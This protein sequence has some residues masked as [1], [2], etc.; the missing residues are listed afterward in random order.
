M[1]KPRPR[2]KAGGRGSS[3]KAATRQ[4][5]TRTHAALVRV[6]ADPE[7]VARAVAGEFVRLAHKRHAKGH[8]FRVALSGGATPRRSYEI[9]AEAPF[10]DMVDWKGV[11]FFWGDERCVPPEHPDSNYRMAL[12]A[13]LS[14]VPVVPAR[15]H[16]IEAERV[17]ADAAAREYQREIARVFGATDD[18]LAPVFDLVLL[19]LGPDGHTASLFPGTSALRELERGVVA[20]FVPKLGARRMT[21]TYPLLNRAA[22]LL[23]VTTGAE[24]S[25]ILAEV[26]EGPEDRERLPA[27]GVRPS[28]G[29]LTWLVD[30]EAAAKLVRTAVTKG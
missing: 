30:A 9:L 2:T 26:L 4:K 22:S 25:A 14:R 16:R 28:A 5:S 19:G 13:L 10:R 17:D 8:A 12:E 27:Q 29:T 7:T 24:K 11:H 6:L 18:A 20:N 3:G 1:T 21:F 15:V 23:F